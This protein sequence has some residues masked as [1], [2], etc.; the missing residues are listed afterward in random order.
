[1]IWRVIMFWLLGASLSLANLPRHCASGL[2]AL[3]GYTY[4]AVADILSI[5]DS[6]YSGAASAAISGVSYDDL[7]R[8]LG[9]TRPTGSV[10]CTYDSVG[11]M[12]KNTENGSAAY[13]Y[14]TPSGTHLPHAI[15]T[16]N[17]LNYTY[18][19]CG[20]ML[21]RGSQALVYNPE[22]RLIASAVSNQVT[23][24]GYD[25]DGNRLWKQGAPTNTL[26]VW[27]E[28]NY[29][30][31][32]GKILFHISAGKRLVCTFDA[33]NTVSEY[34]IPDHLHSAE[35]MANASGGL[36]QHYEYTAYGN[37]RYT[38]STTAF[39]I[40]RRYTSQAFDEET[41][42]YYYG[43]R[44]YDPVIGRFIQPDTLIPNPFD[45]Q[46]YDRYAYARDNPLF[47]VDPSGHGPVD[48]VGDA[49]FNTGTFK[50][51]YELMTMPDSTA[52]KFLEIPVAAGGMAVATAD[53]AFN[54]VT[55]GGKGA[56]EGGVKEVIKTGIEEVGKTEAAKVVKTE[57]AGAAA[58]ESGTASAS[59]IK[60]SYV[61]E[62]ESGKKYF[63]KGT[64]KRMQQSAKDV[65]KANNDKVV[66]SEFEPSN[67]NT[68]KQAFRD[69]AKKL[70]KA[71]GV[72]NKNLYNKINSP[73]KKDLPPQP[74]PPSPAQ[75]TP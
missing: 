59:E 2:G 40:T 37:S 44:Y 16:A 34:Y 31:K 64:E 27:I 10:T 66:K 49:L 17:G 38:Y 39:P 32:D 20:N 69:E 4:D 3:H 5:G 42:L 51:S 14:S 29:E 55:L 72:P 21:T 8:L 23:T 60:G 57:A 22:N 54:L 28:G 41:G 50:S 61:H 75:A 35:I 63:G 13:T 30:E 62:F 71:G 46:A 70:Q 9:F 18:D 73:G 53:T 43:S 67:P 56:V 65:A 12:L 52:W 11:N 24:F 33:S 74:Q 6:A 36:Y 68:D 25:A 19:L 58:A 15:K 1:M 26:Q 7:H 47:Y 45:P 48:V